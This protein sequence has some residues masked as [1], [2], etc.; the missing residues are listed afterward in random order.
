MSEA[1][2][3]IKRS[4]LARLVGGANGPVAVIEQRLRGYEADGVVSPEMRSERI[5]APWLMG[6]MNAQ[7]LTGGSATVVRPH[8]AHWESRATEGLAPLHPIRAMPSF[9]V[10]YYSSDDVQAISPY[11]RSL[12]PLRPDFCRFAWGIETDPDAVPV[13]VE[14]SEDAEISTG[15]LKRLLVGAGFIT[16]DGGAPVD[17]RTVIENA[18]MIALARAGDP[19]RGGA[20]RWKS[21]RLFEEAATRCG[22]DFHYAPTKPKAATKTSKPAD[23]FGDAVRALAKR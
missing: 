3:R 21:Q 14:P 5:N 11:E 4:D 12:S 23:A 17:W 9:D 1:D 15:E 22:Y 13:S 18:R 2:K 19:K 7:G 16:K 6:S 8:D 20:G 10:A